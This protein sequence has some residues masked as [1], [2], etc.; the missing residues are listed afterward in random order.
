VLSHPASVD[1]IPTSANKEDHVSMGMAAALKA[2]RIFDN[3]SFVVAIEMLCA[4]QGLDF[5]K[6]LKAGAGAEAAYDLIRSRIEH[7]ADDRIL[8]YDINTVREMVVSGE[9][10]EAVE[11]RIGKLD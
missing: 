8:H 10:L 4:A 9:V 5:R 6:P 1:S 3:A 2:R 11:K 7:L